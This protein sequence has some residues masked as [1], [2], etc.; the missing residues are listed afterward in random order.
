MRD[1]QDAYRGLSVPELAREVLYGKLD[2]GIS[3]AVE[4]CDRWARN[5]RVALHWI[6]KNF[7]EET[8]TFE[9][10]RDQS[11]RFANL[12]RTRGIG[13]GDVVASL[14][15][16]IPELLAVML[17][18]WRVGA[19]YQ[20]LFTAFGPSAIESRVTSARGSQARLIVTDGNNRPKLDGLANCP[21]VMLGR[22]RPFD[23]GRLRRRARCAVASVR[24]SDAERFRQNSRRQGQLFFHRVAHTRPS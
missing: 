7:A 10:L 15:P 4:C 16:R 9:T 2:G 11:S 5:G 3:A 19:I 14:L 8:V 22:P 1:Y 23:A 17:G 12:L 20:P 18:I 13:Q 6:G 21:P 24:S